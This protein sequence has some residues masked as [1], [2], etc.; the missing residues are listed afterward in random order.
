MHIERTGFLY[1]ADT[2]GN[3]VLAPLINPDSIPAEL[4]IELAA[5]A[6]DH[7]RHQEV[8]DD[9]EWRLREDGELAPIL[10]YIQDAPEWR[11]LIGGDVE[12]SP[13]AYEAGKQAV[14]NVVDSSTLDNQSNSIAERAAL[15]EQAIEVWRTTNA[16]DC[17]LVLGRGDPEGADWFRG[18]RDQEG[19]LPP[20]ALT[21]E[22]YAEFSHDLRK[23]A[24]DNE[25]FLAFIMAEYVHDLAKSGA[26]VR[27]ANMAGI[28]TVGHTH[29]DILHDVIADQNICDTLLPTLAKVKEFSPKA[30]DL[31]VEILSINVNY[32]QLLTGEAPARVINELRGI[33]PQV[34]GLFFFKHRLDIAGALG[35]RQHAGSLT[36]DKE[37]YQDMV[38]LEWA[39]TTN[40]LPDDATARYK[41]YIR[42]RGLRMGSE[43]IYE[44]PARDQDALYARIM[45]AMRRR[46]HEA[47][48]FEQILQDFDHAP[49]IVDNILTTLLNR[50][51]ID[52]KTVRAGY[53]QA[54]LMGMA[55]DP[56]FADNY[57]TIYAMF[58]HEASLYARSKSPNDTGI[59]DADLGSIATA[60]N[61][62]STDLRSAIRFT[63]KASDD[64]GSML[65]PVLRKPPVETL[66]MLDTFDGEFLR[67]KRIMMIGM[68]GGAD[69]AHAG[70]LGGVIAQKYGATITGIMTFRRPDQTLRGGHHFGV[71]A[72]TVHPDSIAQG[73]WSRGNIEQSLVKAL[74]PDNQLKVS[75]SNADNHAKRLADLEAFRNL[76]DADIIIAV[77][78]GGDSF[79]HRGDISEDSAHLA[80]EKDHQVIAALT[81]FSKDQGLPIYTAGIGPANYAKDYSLSLM[82]QA[83]TKILPLSRKDRGAMVE[84]YDILEMLH[85]D[86]INY[87]TTAML[88]HRAT[89]G[90]LGL[91][92]IDLPPAVA[93]SSQNPW[94]VFFYITQG[95]GEITMTEIARHHEVISSPMR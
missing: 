83:S 79:S 28:D 59:A 11:Y 48:I 60:I 69:N 64:E 94:R 37:T 65:Y 7:L 84:A 75:I 72:T 19:N 30:Y 67:N 50:H 74:R 26:L 49:E 6:Q 12:V 52:D 2:A 42:K 32:A 89:L 93:T 56:Q 31:A 15:S 62:K 86:D 85:R 13:E 76:T 20:N 39:I 77:D 78:P 16:V 82:Q 90:Q 66:E 91:Q 63:V 41:A 88:F 73:S 35:H 34:L 27:L 46:V 33:D 80:T 1:T 18:R 54:M 3:H 45:I 43:D 4:Q 24:G 29:D 36:M 58:L 95:M 5:Y 92:S 8:H 44:L 55:K 23:L 40:E 17:T 9:G 61:K 14:H 53:S 57:L 51:G 22:Q 25:G 38:D 47:E 70:A 68:S 21:D 87:S 71:S 81:E 10:A